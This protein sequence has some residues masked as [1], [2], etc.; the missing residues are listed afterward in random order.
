MVHAR[1]RRER[2]KVQGGKTTRERG[3]RGLRGLRG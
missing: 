1:E 2:M 3:R